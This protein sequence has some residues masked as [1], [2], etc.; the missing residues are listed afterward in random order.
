MKSFVESTVI[1][2][3]RYP[4]CCAVVGPTRLVVGNK[5]AAM[6]LQAAAEYARYQG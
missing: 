2:M 4:A 1:G 5:R 6:L 3:L